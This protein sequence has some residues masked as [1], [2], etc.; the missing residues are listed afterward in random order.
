M[1]ND[2]DSSLINHEFTLSKEISYL[3]H[4]AVAPWPERTRQAIS[5]FAEE[6]ATV[7]ASKY[8]RW[9]KTETETREQLQNL[10]N[11]PSVN[12]IAFL[13]NTS[14]ALSVVAYG[15]VW[16]SGDNV[17]TSSEE[18]PSNRIV[19]Q[20]LK[21]KGVN[22]VEVDLYSSNSPEEA[23][24][25]Q[26]NNSTR[27]ISI[28]SVQYASGLRIDLEIIGQ[29]CRDKNI[30]F[31]IDAIQSIGALEFDVEKYQAD[32]VMADAHKW[33]LSPEGIALFY[34]RED[35]RELLKLNQFGWH[36]IENHMDYTTKEWDTAKSARR[37]ECG[38]PNMLG[39]H[40]LN[41]SLSLLL[42]IGMDT[43]EDKLLENT[44]SLVKKLEALNPVT[45]LSSM[46]EQRYAGIVTF[47]HDTANQSDLYSYLMKNNVICAERGGGIRFSPHFYTSEETM[48]RAV[49]MVD[50]YQA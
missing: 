9:M 39:I 22:L 10:I 19:W 15:L 8:P 26:C 17:V 41:A 16:N 12:D 34:C 6:N 24:I 1:T 46:E 20:S 5:L 37:F 28:S 13:K 32:F 35:K 42:E 29:F 14:E 49:A 31:C 38:S 36:M 44:R 23:I 48:D 11:A 50:S 2:L 47:K 3:N 40:A 27:L 21:D 43:I 7:G 4:A 18:F 25:E 45:I 33:M 30:L